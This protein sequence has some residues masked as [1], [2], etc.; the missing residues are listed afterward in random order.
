MGLIDGIKLIAVLFFL[1]IVGIAALMPFWALYIMYIGFTS[2]FWPGFG[3]VL[4]G[5]VLF[6]IG[7]VVDFIL[8]AAWADS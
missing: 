3:E 6:L 4:L 2:P 1:I 8:L 5:G 7:L